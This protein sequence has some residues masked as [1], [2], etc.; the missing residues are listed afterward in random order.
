MPLDIVT[1]SPVPADTAPVPLP[2]EHPEAPPTP[3]LVRIAKPTPC[4]MV[5]VTLKNV[6]DDTGPIRRPGIV[7]RGK[8][9]DVINARVFLDPETDW[10]V[11][12]VPVPDS[13]A[14]LNLTHDDSDGAP[15]GTWRFPPFS[16]AKLS[17]ER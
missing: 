5:E 10:R 9:A 3:A 1:A 14:A 8:D 16:A 17:V 4:R 11:T 15:A 13:L 2:A 7:I 12:G 6:G